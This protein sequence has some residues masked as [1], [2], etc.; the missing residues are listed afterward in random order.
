MPVLHAY[1]AAAALPQGRLEILP[2]CGYVPQI[3]A[4]SSF[5]Q[6]LTAFLRNEVRLAA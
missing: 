3:E 6:L 1:A 5:A 2:T 4:P